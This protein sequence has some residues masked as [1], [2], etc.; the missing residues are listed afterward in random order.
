[1]MGWNRR[2]G[3]AGYVAGTVERR[4]E[5]LLRGFGLVLFRRRWRL[6]LM[7]ARVFRGMRTDDWFIAHALAVYSVGG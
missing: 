7:I 2:A 1:M 4:G 3:Y 5:M 6:W